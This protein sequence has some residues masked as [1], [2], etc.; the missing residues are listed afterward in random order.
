ME[1]RFT[2]VERLQRFR[3]RFCPRRDCP[4]HLR[5]TPG[6]RAYV[7]G[8]ST[9]KNGASST[10]FRCMT[11]GGTF[12]QKAFSPT[13]YM[14]RPELLVPVAAGL[15][16]GSA[17]RQIARLLDCA[18]STVTRLSYRAGRH[19]LLVMA[20]ALEAL[21][22][23]LQESVVLDHFET[24]EFSQDL[25]FGVATAV[26][27]R[28]W[29][30]Y[31]LDPAPHHRTG[32]R[33]ASQQQRVESRPKRPHHGGYTGSTKRII[34]RLM[35]LS[36]ENLHL[37]TDDH[38]SYRRVIRRHPKKDRIRHEI[39]PNPERDGKDS[40]RSRQA[41]RRD[42]AMF[43]CDLLH[44]LVRHSMA[45]HRRETIAF[46]RRL[47]ALVLRIYG[48]AVWR[49]F[50]KRRSERSGSDT[51]PAMMLGLTDRRWTWR[52]LFS[53]RMFP[54][55][56]RLDPMEQKLYDQRWE[57]PVLPINAMHALRLAY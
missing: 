40:P 55:R 37:V 1:W 50:V 38:G 19:F 53:W 3:P 39:H 44:G 32:R 26:G 2:P 23:K 49:N 33:T 20:A 52:Q 13:Y 28:S 35:P 27:Q 36:E 24:F 22:N 41:V 48:F 15:V 29:F 10:R 17:H 34:E 42:R 56:F 25:P 51:T 12:S 45:A 43:A 30:V 31:G 9:R 18:P 7:H 11:C 4:D 6:Y 21:K 5:T 47:N 54:D 8:Y 16:S 14:K 46:G 57:T